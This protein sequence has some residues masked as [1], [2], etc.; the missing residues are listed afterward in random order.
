MTTPSKPTV[1]TVP[2]CAPQVPEHE[3]VMSGS[4][5]PANSWASQFLRLTQPMQESIATDFN[6]P[7]TLRKTP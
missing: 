6:T 1:P 2:G 3:R 4:V 7:T 5:N